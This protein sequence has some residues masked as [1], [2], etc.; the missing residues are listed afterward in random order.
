[1]PDQAAQLR[2][3]ANHYRRRAKAVGIPG[4]AAAFNEAAEH[5]EEII[6]DIPERPANASYCNSEKILSI[7]PRIRG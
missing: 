1:M 5:L 6:A 2:E 3:L 7:L 4:F